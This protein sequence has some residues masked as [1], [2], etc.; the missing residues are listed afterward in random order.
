MWQKFE[1]PIFGRTPMI[2]GGCV[3]NVVPASEETLSERSQHPVI[4][5]EELERRAKIANRMAASFGQIVALMARSDAHR[6]TNLAELEWLIM[7]A[8]ASGQFL[9]AE[10]QSKSLGLV[11]PIAAVLWACVSDEVDARLCAS[12]DRPGRL[13]PEEWRSG[14]TIWIIEAFGEPSA[15]QA[16]IEKLKESIFAEKRLKIRVAQKNSGSRIIEI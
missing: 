10:A 11:A 3:E 1:Q 13:R 5:T 4:S 8:I 16:L 7:P 12:A 15:R 2:H 9:I 6:L 14:S